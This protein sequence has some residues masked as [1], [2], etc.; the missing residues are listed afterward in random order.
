MLTHAL[1][2]DCVV[3]LHLLF[4]LSRA[5]GAWLLSAPASF[6]ELQR[7]LAAAV[8][9]LAELPFDKGAIAR[10]SCEAL[11]VREQAM[12]AEAGSAASEPQ[13]G[14]GSGW[15]WVTGIAQSGPVPGADLHILAISAEHGVAV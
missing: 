9:V 7:L 2:A 14:L 10:L 1:L 8:T 11:D 5:H 3:S 15:F 13:L 6:A 12:A 4:L